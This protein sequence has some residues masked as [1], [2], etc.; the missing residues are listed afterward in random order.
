M[1]AYTQGNAVTRAHPHETALHFRVPV[2]RSKEA[3]S[4]SVA[5]RWRHGACDLG[6]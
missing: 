6:R 2:S 4:T 1:S 5:I 3:I